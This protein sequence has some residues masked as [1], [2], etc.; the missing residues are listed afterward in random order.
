[1][2]VVTSAFKSNSSDLTP[3]VSITDFHGLRKHDDANACRNAE[4]VSR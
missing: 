2:N 4:S 3:R 1:M